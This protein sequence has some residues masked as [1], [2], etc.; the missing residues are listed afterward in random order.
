MFKFLSGTMVGWVAA[1]SIDENNKVLLPTLDEIKKISEK[2]Q[3]LYEQILKKIQDF[4]G[5][6]EGQG[7]K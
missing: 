5:G 7:P 4:D 6:A 1:R 2:S 3:K